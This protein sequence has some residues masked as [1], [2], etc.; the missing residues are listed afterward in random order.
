VNSETFET[1][2][3]TK[4]LAEMAAVAQASL[5]GDGAVQII[6]IAP[7]NRAGP[8]HISFLTNSR[9]RRFLGTTS[10]G[11][12]I[13]SPRDADR[14]AVPVLISKNPQLAYAR[15][16]SLFVSCHDEP[17]GI[18]PS[19]SVS[20]RAQIGQGVVVGPLCAVGD[21]AVL[22]AGVLL[23][24]GCVVGRNA[25]LGRDTRLVAN[26]TVCDGVRIGCRGLVHPGAVIGS[27]GFGLANDAGRW[28]KIPQLGSVRIGDDVEIGAN[29]TIDRGAL[30][31]TII[32]EGV[33][34]D[35]QI[36]VAHNVRIGAHTAVA[37][38]VGIAGSAKIGRYCNLG[39]GVG[40]AGH[41]E[42]ADRVSI[43]GM[44]LVTKSITEPGMYSSGLAVEPNRRWNKISA[45]L[46]RIDELAKSLF[47]IEKKLNRI[48]SG[49]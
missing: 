18:H 25:V 11:A 46:R 21:G 28:V 20:T 49:G 15:V 33:K 41:L 44:S 19:A 35:N 42:I 5:R 12:V 1:K 26:V 16:A 47:A 37:G 3:E 39:G 6:G 8:N 27:D 48:R 7:L 45:R 13:V 31:D 38:C 30:E 32:E 10:A 2:F 29:T 24:P 9:Y 40:I 17:R 14:C 22:E 23:G 4:T 36:Q 34:L 43:T